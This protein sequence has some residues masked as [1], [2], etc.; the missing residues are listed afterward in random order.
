MCTTY[1]Q[2]AAGS[3]KQ[4]PP[5]CDFGGLITS[6]N[7]CFC[8]IPHVFCKTKKKVLKCLFLIMFTAIL[9]TLPKPFYIYVYKIYKSFV[10]PQSS[11]CVCVCLFMLGYK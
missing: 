11:V 10:V 2:T 8:L 1:K 3:A 5:H 7:D 9:F 4:K 6:I